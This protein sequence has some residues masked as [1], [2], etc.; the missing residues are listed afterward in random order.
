MELCIMGWKRNKDVS[1]QDQSSPLFQYYLMREDKDDITLTAPVSTDDDV[2]NVSAGH[3]F[4]AA[5]GE[6]LVLWENSGYEQASVD[7]QTGTTN[8][9][10][11]LIGSW[12]PSCSRGRE[13]AWS[14]DTSSSAIPA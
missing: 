8:Y 11:Q 5:S 13:R 2:I 14:A 7:M 4:T 12:R 6:Q 9:R 1:I 3:G 10:V